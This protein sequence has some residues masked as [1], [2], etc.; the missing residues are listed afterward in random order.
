M[1]IATVVRGLIVACA[2][3]WIVAGC[4]APPLTL[5]T[6][7]GSADPSAPPHAELS[8]GTKPTVI[9]LSR[10]TVPDELDTEDIVVRDG[11]TLRRSVQGRWASR[12]SLGITAQLTRRLAERRPDA[13]VTDRPQAEAPSYRIVINVSRLDVTTGG[14][15]TLEADWL[16]VPHDT[17]I[18]THRD[19]ARFTVT[20]P[21]ATD[22]DVVTLDEALLDRL[23]AVIDISTLR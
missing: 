2:A 17:A 15:A 13:L 20:G 7:G 21:A 18:T 23:A 3:A 10:V 16:I 12:L 6:L 1:S 9:E 4:A 22:Q 11:S 14:V 5:Y 8:L 19:R